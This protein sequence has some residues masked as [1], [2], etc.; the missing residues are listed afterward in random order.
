APR[1]GDVPARDPADGRGRDLAPAALR[2]RA[3]A[4]LARTR[5]GR[6]RRRRRRRLPRRIAPRPR[7]A[8]A[9]RGTAAADCGPDR[10]ARAA[11]AL[12]PTTAR[13][14]RPA[15]MPARGRT[16]QHRAR[17][18]DRRRRARRQ[19]AG[20]RGR[21]RALPAPPPGRARPAAP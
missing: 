16:P 1:A 12:T 14:T 19:H 7:A 15:I 6:D 8:A 18:P 5:R 11:V 20:T 13:S 4:A 9:V 2:Q 10:L 3:L 21:P 17:P